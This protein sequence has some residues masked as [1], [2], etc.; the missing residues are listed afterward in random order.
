MMRLEDSQNVSYKV[1][2]WRALVHLA[3]I[4]VGDFARASDIACSIW[5]DHQMTAQGAGAAA[6][7]ILKRM[8]KEGLVVWTSNRDDWGYRITSMGRRVAQEGG[9]G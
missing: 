5:P 8:E 4:H 1:A 3:S 6:S 9:E 2:R 7:R